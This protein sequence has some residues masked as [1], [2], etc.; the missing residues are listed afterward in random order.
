MS[1]SYKE[2]F[3]IYS[4]EMPK[5]I[6]EGF[7]P[8]SVSDVM[9][10]RINSRYSEEKSKSYWLNNYFDTIDAIAYHPNNKMKI[11]FDSQ[12]LKDVNSESQFHKGSLILEDSVYESLNGFEFTRKELENNL[13]KWFNAKQIKSNP[14]W[15]TLAR[16]Q[17]LL[18]EYSEYILSEGKIKFGT[19][20]DHAMAIYFTFPEK[21]PTMRAL[22]IWGMGLG[23]CVFGSHVLNSGFSRVVGT[24]E[25]FR[26]L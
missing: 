17:N 7:N 12:N 25:K 22:N 26:K 20:Y 24:I 4:E 6:S 1:E 5:L 13:W 19:N 11:V 15:K 10:N 14:I 9:V 23:S 8:I 16:D 21:I 2:F 18:E 3:G